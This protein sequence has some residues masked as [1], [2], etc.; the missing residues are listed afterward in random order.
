LPL[1][2]VCGLDFYFNGRKITG[3]YL[4]LYGNNE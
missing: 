3:F 1:K 4:S 2:L